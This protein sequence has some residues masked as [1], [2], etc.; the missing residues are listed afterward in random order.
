[1][2]LSNPV[3][4]VKTQ[5]WKF[6]VSGDELEIA[7]PFDSCPNKGQPQFYINKH[8]GK[9]ICFRCDNKGNN[10]K[11]LAFKLK[12]VQLQEPLDSASIFVPQQEVAKMHKMLLGTKDAMDYLLLQRCHKES[13]IKQFQLG[14]KIVDGEPAIVFPI[15]DKNLHCVGM[16]YD[17]YRR[18]SGLPKYKFE[19]NSKK[20][21][22]NLAYVDLSQPLIITEGYHDAIS[23]WEYGLENVGSIPNGA[24]SYS[25]EWTQEL[26]GCERFILAFDNDPAGVEGAKK[27]GEQL[28]LSK[29]YRVQLRVKDLNDAAQHEIPKEEVLK[30]FGSPE[31]MFKVP[32]MNLSAYEEDVKATLENPDDYRGYSTGWKMFDYHIGGIKKPGVTVFSGITKHGKS[33]FS[34]ALIG[35]LIRQGIKCLIISPEM[36]EAD[37]VLD[38]ASNFYKERVSQYDKVHEFI[39]KVQENVFIANVFNQWTED[40]PDSLLK[41]VFDLVD[42]SAKNLGV[43]FVLIDHMRLFINPPTSGDERFYTERFMKKCVLA[44]I[45]SKIHVWLVVQPGK[46]DVIKGKVRKLT[47]NDLKGTANITQDASNIV[48]I[49]RDVDD[50]KEMNL[51][52]VEVCGVRSKLGQ[53]GTFALEFDTKSKANYY[54]VN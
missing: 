51:V 52:E 36:A 1:M 13:A 22:Y 5:G 8:T 3:E 35:N 24:N 34:H 38:L 43:E 30:W 12:L 11:S 20:Q 9:W 54:E 47:Y 16:H 23:A 17:F 37:I 14:I 31:P 50:S 45:A 48:L 18:P 6:R 29:C 10:L 39:E 4:F 7:C 2:N 21:L 28:G 41:N 27:L 32:V 15:F 19:K 26:N 42:Y 44:S 25:G 49:H 40:K 53:T 33:S 46:L